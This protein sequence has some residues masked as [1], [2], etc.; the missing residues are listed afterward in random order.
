MR[1]ESLLTSSGLPKL[2]TYPYPFYPPG[3]VLSSFVPLEELG[4]SRLVQGFTEHGMF[5]MSK[6]LS[7]S[8]EKRESRREEKGGDLCGDGGVEG[9]E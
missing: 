9:D 4:R 8:P 3:S 5:L 1:F 2:R 6:P 7:R